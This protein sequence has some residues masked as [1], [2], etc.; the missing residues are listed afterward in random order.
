MGDYMVGIAISG[1]M[2]SGKTTL[3]DELLKQVLEHCP[4]DD[5][6]TKVSLATPVKQVAYDYFLMLPSEKDRELLQQIGQ[7]FRQIKNRVWVDLLLDHVH[8]LSDTTPC[9]FVICDDMRFQNELEA[10]QADGWFTIRL[11]VDEE[12][13]KRRLEK[14]YGEEWETHW[15]NRN[16][17]S[18]TDLDGIEGFNLTIHNLP[19]EDVP[20]TAS[21]IIETI[22]EWIMRPQP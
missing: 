15:E 6:A 19:L 8:G 20:H 21:E 12:E 13:Q 17:I 2:G 3:A 10:L 1:K 22:T 11:T 4:N 16:E 18:E 5:H 9:E 14:A 7:R